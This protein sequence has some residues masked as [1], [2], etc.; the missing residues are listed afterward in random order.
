M[1]SKAL[2]VFLALMAGLQFISAASD[3]ANL[4]SP[5]VAAWIQLLVGAAQAAMA[6]YVGKV[7]LTPADPAHPDNL[8]S[9]QLENLAG[10]AERRENAL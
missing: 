4:T 5:T 2:G 1:N 8:T 7:A 6:V 9:N 10:K 3:L